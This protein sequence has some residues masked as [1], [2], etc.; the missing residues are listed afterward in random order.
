MRFKR[1][2]II[3]FRFWFLLVFG[4]SEIKCSVYSHPFIVTVILIVFHFRFPHKDKCRH[5]SF[6]FLDIDSVFD[7]DTKANFG[8]LWN[9]IDN[10]QQNENCFLGCLFDSETSAPSQF[11]FILA[12]FHIAWETAKC[13]NA[14]A[15]HTGI[16]YV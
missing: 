3:W 15:L 13:W 11:K 6:R 12:S 4:F 16:S 1:F 8:S 5:F 9:K 10:Q 14:Q 2:Q 7:L